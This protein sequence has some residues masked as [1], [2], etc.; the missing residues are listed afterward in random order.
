MLKPYSRA[1]SLLKSLDRN[2]EIICAGPPHALIIY[3]VS[4]PS[5]ITC[6]RSYSETKSLQTD[7]RT[8]RDIT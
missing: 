7:G 4:V 5:D 2:I 6:R 1:V 3:Q 8:P